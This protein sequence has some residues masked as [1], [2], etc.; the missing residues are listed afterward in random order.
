LTSFSSFVASF[1]VPCTSLR[2]LFFLQTP[3]RLK[4]IVMTSFAQ[5]NGDSGGKDVGPP[6]LDRLAPAEFCKWVHR[7]SFQFETM[8]LIVLRSFIS[9][10]RR[11]PT[12]CIRERVLASPRN[13]CYPPIQQAKIHNLLLLFQ[14]PSCWS[15]EYDGHHACCPL[16]W[17]FVCDEFIYYLSSSIEKGLVL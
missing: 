7:F 16:H 13:V 1:T 15:L 5:K 12:P 8:N 9:T 2:V 4:K 3:A 6:D 14:S 17:C 10:Q 11:I